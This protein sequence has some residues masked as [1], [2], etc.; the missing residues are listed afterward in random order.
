MNKHFK[1]FTSFFVV[2]FLLLGFLSVQ[3][4]FAATDSSK[5]ITLTVG[6][7]QTFTDSDWAALGNSSVTDFV[8]IPALAS[9]YGSTETGYKTQLA[10]IVI[11]AINKLVTYRSTAKIWIGTPGIASSNYG[12][13]STS[14]N[15]FYNYIT[16]IQ[17]Q[18]GTTKWSN[19]IRGVYMNEEAVYGTVD[20]SNIM[21]NAC[22]ALMNNLSYR[23]HTNLVKKF[24]WIPYYGY[25]SDPATIIKNIGYVADKYT[26]FDYVIIQPHYYFDSTVQSNLNGVYYSVNAQKVCYR[27]GV[28]VIA[29]KGSST[30]IGVEMESSWRLEYPYT[31][32]DYKSRYDEYV[33][34]FSEFKGTYPFAFYWDGTITTAL[35]GWINP[36]YN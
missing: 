17:A 18:I 3:S 32:P 16:Y 9:S 6:Q 25:G 30:I 31:Y 29:S 2:V 1:R 35:D 11:N 21:A 10:P 19:N 8:I 28:A 22:I 36:F 33:S 7:C 13:A 12:I 20:Y 34:K 23:V 14:L 24:L 5:M 4:V 27:D 26:I 15:P